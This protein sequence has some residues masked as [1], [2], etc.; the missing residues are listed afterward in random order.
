MD[1]RKIAPIVV[2][3]VMV[4]YFIVYFGFIVSVTNFNLVVF[5][6]G[7]VITLALTITLIH[8]IIQRMNE[9]ESGE[10]DDISK[11]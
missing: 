3:I 8:V 4:I 7:G 9:I 2:G 11:Y 6:I 5:V 1:S 10:E